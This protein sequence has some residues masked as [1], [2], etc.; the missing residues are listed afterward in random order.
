MLREIDGIAQIPLR[1]GEAPAEPGSSIDAAC[2]FGAGVAL[3]TPLLLGGSLA[4]PNTAG[5]RSANAIALSTPRCSIDTRCSKRARLTESRNF[6]FGRARLRPS[7][8]LYRR[9]LFFRRRGAQSTPLLLGGSL[10][11]PNAV[12][13]RSANAIAQSTPLFSID[14]ALLVARSA[15][16]EFDGIAQIPLREGEAPAEPG[17]LSTPL[18][19]SAP[20]GSI[21]AALLGGSLA[22]PNA[23]CL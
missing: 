17:A 12:R 9:R 5:T 4:L 16:R 2:S 15:R 8:E 13:T 20:D 3:S 18:V 21:D 23:G 1:E 14:T 11:L 10:A 7:R 22:L 19:L 6:L